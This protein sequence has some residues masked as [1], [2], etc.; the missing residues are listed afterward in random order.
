MNTP[1]PIIRATQPIDNV[2]MVPHAIFGRPI[3]YFTLDYREAHDD[4][5][6]FKF[7]AFVLNNDCHFSLRH[8]R[9]HPKQTVT[10][11]LE[12][13]LTEL[14]ELESIIDAIIKGFKMP[15]TAVRWRRGDP[16]EYGRLKPL[17]GRL[18][19]PEARILTL[20]IASSQPRGRASTTY[21]KEHIPLFIPLTRQDLQRSST[22]KNE[23]M[24]QQVAGNVISHK[25]QS[26]SI[27]SLGYAL[28]T[29]DGIRI[30]DSGKSLLDDLG[31]SS[32]HITDEDRYI[33]SRKDPEFDFGWE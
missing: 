24:W 13:Q 3:Q 31:F 27:F 17:K 29:E 30:T 19:E 2:D 18:R 26:T 25:S 33:M 14:P 4:L 23:Q 21:I 15:E 20:K 10:V 22:R 6:V 5:D 28:R 32:K 16:V 8:Y 9:G 1:E 7:A 11:Y 12:Y